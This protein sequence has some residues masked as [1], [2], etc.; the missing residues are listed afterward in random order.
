MGYGAVG[1]FVG[2]VAMAHNETGQIPALTGRYTVESALAGGAVNWLLLASGMGVD[3]LSI[4]KAMLAGF[5][6]GYMWQK[7]LRANV[8]AWGLL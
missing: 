6:G 3:N 2:A 4:G 5:A 7:M 8:V 1:G